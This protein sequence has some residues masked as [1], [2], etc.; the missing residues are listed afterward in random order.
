MQLVHLPILRVTKYCGDLA[1]H[2]LSTFYIII[3]YYHILYSM[4]MTVPFNFY[5]GS[6]L[7]DTFF[8]C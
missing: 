4:C 8:L 2:I 5:V 1:Q 7:G 3:I 6:Y